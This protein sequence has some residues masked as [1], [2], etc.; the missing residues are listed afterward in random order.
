V[1]SALAGVALTGGGALTV[2]LVDPALDYLSDV[3]TFDVRV[4][5]TFSTGRAR[6]KAFVDLVNATNFSTILAQ[7]TT[8]GSTWLQPTAATAG[9]YVRLGMELTF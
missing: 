1:N 5:R 3:K 7:S 9:R 2:K 6:T 4:T 8:F